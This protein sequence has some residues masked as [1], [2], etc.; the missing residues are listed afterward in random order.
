MP[1]CDRECP[2][3]SDA[4]TGIGD[5]LHFIAEGAARRSHD[6]EGPET[7]TVDGQGIGSRVET[8]D[9]HPAGT[10]GLD[11][12]GIRFDREKDHPLAGLF[13]EIGRKILPCL[14]VDGGILDRRTGEDQRMRVH[15][16]TGIGRNVGQR[17][18]VAIAEPRIGI[19]SRTVLRRSRRNGRGQCP[20]IPS[21]TKHRS[22]QMRYLRLPAGSCPSVS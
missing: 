15:P 8:G 20:Q 17:I 14:A 9:V 3:P 13:L 19:A 2:R 11:L 5:D 21:C 10:H 6:G 4:G 16:P 12:G 18:S 22:R 7:G 1:A